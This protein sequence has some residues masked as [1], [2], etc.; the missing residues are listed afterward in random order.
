MWGS[1]EKRSIS[2]RVTTLEEKVKELA[3]Q[4]EEARARANEAVTLVR[5]LASRLGE[6]IDE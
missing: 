1:E 3:S 2:D 5:K 4:L 6:E